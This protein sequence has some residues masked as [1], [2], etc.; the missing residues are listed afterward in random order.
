MSKEAVRIKGRFCSQLCSK[1]GPWVE[2][3]G[4]GMSWGVWQGHARRAEATELRMDHYEYA[5]DVNMLED[6]S[7]GPQITSTELLS[8]IGRIEDNTSGPRHPVSYH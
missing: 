3:A 5:N 6:R 4:A 8:R 2:S 7:T 1:T